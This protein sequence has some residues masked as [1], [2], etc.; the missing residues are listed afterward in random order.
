LREALIVICGYLR[1]NIIE[2]VW[3]EIFGVAQS[4]ISGSSNLTGMGFLAGYL[5]CSPGGCGA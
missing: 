3:A 2:D 4:T 5:T 1:Q